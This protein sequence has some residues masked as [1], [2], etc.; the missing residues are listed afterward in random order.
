MALTCPSE[1]IV[2]GATLSAFN[3][4]YIQSGTRTFVEEDRPNIT[5]TRTV[6]SKDG[7]IASIPRIDF[8]SPN[9]GQFNWTIIG[10]VT[11]NNGNIYENVEIFIT[12]NY[13]YRVF[14]N[15]PTGLVFTPTLMAFLNA[16]SIN[17]DPV[18]VR[19]DKYATDTE[20][21]SHRFKRLFT[22]GYV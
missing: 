12:S 19:N 16:P 10:S 21:G 14:P 13:N 4:T 7:N 17:V 15:C 18:V 1:I 22:L 20:T 6:Y 8:G 2:E 11:A 9:L 3:G 5:I